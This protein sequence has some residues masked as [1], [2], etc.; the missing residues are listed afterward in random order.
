MSQS[1]QSPQGSQVDPAVVST[2]ERSPLAETLR[3]GARQM[4]LKA[5]EAITEVLSQTA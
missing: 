1:E 5:I 4:L 3:G 2:K